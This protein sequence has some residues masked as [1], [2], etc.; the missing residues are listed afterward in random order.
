[1]RRRNNDA[2]A[3][4]GA[5][6]AGGLPLPGRR[7]SAVG[8]AVPRTRRA[9]V[10]SPCVAPGPVL[11]PRPVPALER[12]G[13]GD[14]AAGPAMAVRRRAGRIPRVGRGAAVVAA[15]AGNDPAQRPADLLGPS[16]AA[17]RRVPVAVPQ[18]AS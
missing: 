1:R 16:T 9:S 18:G 14:D 17:P 15:S 13:P 8:G 11:L 7:V 5:H 12:T 4:D 3:V 6:R 10:P 2:D